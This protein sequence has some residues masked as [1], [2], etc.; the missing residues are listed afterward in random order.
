MEKHL[1]KASACHICLKEQESQCGKRR[2][3]KEEWK[4]WG[5]NGWFKDQ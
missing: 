3:S 4:G 2:L 5:D 1:R